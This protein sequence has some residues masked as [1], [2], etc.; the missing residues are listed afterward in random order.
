MLV[1]LLTFELY[2][3]SLLLSNGVK[4]YRFAIEIQTSKEKMFSD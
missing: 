1:H 3:V 2:E 4:I